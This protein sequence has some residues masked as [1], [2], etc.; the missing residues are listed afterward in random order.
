MGTPHNRGVGCSGGGRK[1]WAIVG[2]FGLVSGLRAVSA[3]LLC[4]RGADRDAESGVG[5]A[6]CRGE[7]IR[8]SQVSTRDEPKDLHLSRAF[9]GLSSS[10]HQRGDCVVPTR[11]LAHRAAGRVGHACVQG[12]V[13]AGC[14]G[15]GFAKTTA[16]EAQAD[17]VDALL[18]LHHRAVM[19]VQTPYP[20][21][22]NLSVP[23]FP[24]VAR[25]S[26]SPPAHA[27]GEGLSAR[28]CPRKR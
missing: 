25:A 12:A 15:Y 9:T 4:M 18:G 8:R 24:A 22:V 20:L 7:N 28:S 21:M 14:T 23:K 16:A 26:R 6:Q 1:V 13:L 27:S 17:R 19:R 11:G 2:E 10:M 3:S 5:V